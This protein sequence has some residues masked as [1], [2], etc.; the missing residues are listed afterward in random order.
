MEFNRRYSLVFQKLP[1]MQMVGTNSVIC[2]SD[3]SAKAILH[4]G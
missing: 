2:S 3:H 1:A 4:R